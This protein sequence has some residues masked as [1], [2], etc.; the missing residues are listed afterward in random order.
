MKN[1]LLI[2]LSF[3]VVLAV[4]PEH[5]IAPKIHVTDVYHGI[6]IVDS[7]RYMEDMTD[8]EVLDWVKGQADYAADILDNLPMTDNLLKRLVELD[9]GRP[10]RIYGIHRMKDGGMF[11]RKIRSGDNQAKL[12]YRSSKQSDEQL[13]ID[14]EA[15]SK[16]RDQHFS[17]QFYVPSINGNYLIY[18][19]AEGG[20]EETVIHVKDLKTME[21][22]GDIINRIETAYNRPQWH[23][24]EGFFY[25]RRQNLPEDAPQTE[26]YKNTKTYY[27][28]LGTDPAMDIPI[29]GI[30][31]SKTVK[32]TETDFPSINLSPV[33]PYIVGKVNHGD[34]RE[35]SLF[36]VH[37]DRIFDDRIPWQ[38]ICNES[39]SVETYS[40]RN[41]DIYLVTSKNAP[42]YKIIKTRLDTPELSSAE[43]VFEPSNLVYRYISQSRDRLYIT[44]MDGGY[45]RIIEFDPENDERTFLD[46]PENESAY[47]FSASPWFDEVYVGRSSWTY[48]GKKQSWS[49]TTNQFKDLMLEPPGI[50]DNPGWLESRRVLVKS[51]DGV[52]VPLSIIYGRDIELNG[53]NPTII[54]GYGAYGSSRGVGY[55]STRLAWL[56]QGGVYAIAH[57]RGGGEFGKQWHLDGMMETKPNTW[58]DFIAC[59]QFLIDNGYTSPEFLA[60]Q[61]GSAGGILIGRAITERPDLYRCAVIN[62]GCMDML[63]METT[64]NGV[65]N[66]KEFGSVVTKSGFMALLEMSAFHQV[67][68]GIEYPAVLS[69]HGINDPRVEPW[70]SAK[71]TARLQEA[72]ASDRPIL[73]RVDYDAGHGIGSTKEQRFKQTADIWAFLLWQMGK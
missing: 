26:I 64:T 51:H 18:G 5:L 21:D 40:R 14:P 49:S 6:E 55:R 71:M 15:L 7:Y 9:S 30:G 68:D 28:K 46:I 20:S 17:L 8:P 42:R 1:H 60:G 19:L 45:N 52:E 62:V 11:F 23:G 66:I 12:F 10:F 36:T 70:F 25:C 39:D 38:K 57:V 3:S 32:L 63:R 54:S 33:N 13:I 34:N 53:Q 50:F 31:L 43:T 67:E 44:A 27:H 69:T 72:S 41:E 37:K 61:G 29:F 56:E 59:S 24:E 73:F 35:I 65:P 48:A 2:I 58:K 4:I 16:G 47:I 22:T